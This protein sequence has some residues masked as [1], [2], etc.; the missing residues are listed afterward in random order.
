MGPEEHLD[1]SLAQWKAPEETSEKVSEF[2]LPTEENPVVKAQLG[3]EHTLGSYDRPTRVVMELKDG[4]AI[5]VPWDIARN[6]LPAE[7]AEMAD[8]ATRARIFERHIEMLATAVRSTTDVMTTTG[9]LRSRAMGIIGKDTQ[10]A[11]LL[12]QLDDLRQDFDAF[13]NK[14]LKELQGSV[15]VHH[16][17]DTQVVGI[18]EVQ[19]QLESR[20][21]KLEEEVLKNQDTKS[22]YQ[23]W[24]NE[25][26]LPNP[27]RLRLKE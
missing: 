1:E 11:T 16:L 21:F 2:I 24:V 25:R 7:Y 14:T 15:E 13:A 17:N 5:S 10:A 12:Q 6:H 18:L 26:K 20:Y 22:K 3:L 8:A 23:Q 9:R 4:K 27:E 19:S